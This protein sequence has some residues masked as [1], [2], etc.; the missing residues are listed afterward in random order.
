MQIFD[1]DAYEMIARI[2]DPAGWATVLDIGANVGQSV[3]RIAQTFTKATIHAF[4][5]DP[6][7]YEQLQSAGA[8]CPRLY[9]WQAAVGAKSG[10]VDLNIMG[11]SQMNSVLP[12]TQLGQDYFPGDIL[13]QRTVRVPMVSIDDWASQYKINHV[14]FIK[15]DVQGI[16]LDVL[17]GAQRLIREGGVL[18]IKCEAQILPEYQG[19]STLFDIVPFMQ[20][21]GFQLHQIHDVW[22]H[23]PE[24][25]HSCLDALW[26]RADM[27]QRL[28]EEPAC[29]YRIDWRRRMREA[30][31]ACAANGSRRIAI[32]AAGQHTQACESVIREAR[33]VVCIIDDNPARAGQK[34]ADLPIL[35]LTQSTQLGFDAVVLSSNSQEDAIWEK[36]AALRASGIPVH[37]LYPEPITAAPAS[38]KPKVQASHIQIAKVQL[39]NRNKQEA[40]SPTSATRVTKPEDAFRSTSYLRLNARRLEHL[41]SLGLNLSRKR[42]LEVGAGI[43]DL[44]TFFADRGCTIDATDARADNIESLRKN[45]AN[46]PRVT[47]SLLDMDKPGAFSGRPYDVVFCYGLLYHLRDPEAAIRFMSQA[48]GGMLLLETCVSFGEHEALNPVPEDA[49]V[50]SQATSGTGCRPTR[51]W[52]LRRLRDQFKHVYIPITQPASD[53]FPVDWTATSSTAPLTR[54]IFVA[55]RTPIASLLLTEELLARQ[56][57]A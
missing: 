43:G 15:I 24:R 26:I 4:E 9:T 54:A 42:V 7:A 49:Q 14:D 34:L 17:R 41:A 40:Q 33:N 30:L 53:E 57:A 1:R 19:A 11:D 32:Y 25:Q 29:A 3:R 27:I 5:P 20:S 23:G 8:V 44:T 10:H 47:A 45:F 52:V 55:S 28:R 21:L 13:P 56:S 18:A 39:A 12:P 6:S 16:E 2:V 38:A 31:A 50:H 36:T 35:P 37:R 51:S 22:E 46:D 48:T